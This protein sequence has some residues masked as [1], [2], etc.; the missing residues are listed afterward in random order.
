MKDDE[1]SVHP[2]H[3]SSNYFP[4]HY[5]SGQKKKSRIS[6]WSSHLRKKYVSLGFPGHPRLSNPIPSLYIWLIFMIFKC[7]QKYQSHRSYGNGIRTESL[8]R[9]GIFAP[10]GLA[11]IHPVYERLESPV[12]GHPPTPDTHVRVNMPR[13]RCY[14]VLSED[15]QIHVGPLQKAG[16][17]FVVESFYVALPGTNSKFAPENGCLEYFLVSGWYGLF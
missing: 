10:S 15:R 14:R 9:G 1:P 11:I 2:S 4:T 8:A 13:N 17:I 6:N 7:R 3:S 5:I 16:W 12:P